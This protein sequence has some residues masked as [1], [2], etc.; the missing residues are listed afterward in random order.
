MATVGSIARMEEGVAPATGRSTHWKDGCSSVKAAA[1]V[2]ALLRPT[3][4]D[5][6]QPDPARV[7]CNPTETSG[8]V[9]FSAASPAMR[10]RSPHRARRHWLKGSQL[11]WAA[12]SGVGCSCRLAANSAK[13]NSGGSGQGAGSVCST[14]MPACPSSSSRSSARGRTGRGRVLIR[15]RASRAPSALACSADDAEPTCRTPESPR[16]SDAPRRRR[17]PLSPPSSVLVGRTD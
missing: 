3:T 9:V 5:I 6:R 17:P 8:H 15:I 2:M 4:R 12:R 11:E 10:R 13:A 7:V 16:R 14:R 1:S